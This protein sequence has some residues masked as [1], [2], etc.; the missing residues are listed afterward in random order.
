MIDRHIRLGDRVR[1]A[2]HPESRAGGFD[3][4]PDGTVATVEGF[5]E[6]LVPRLRRWGRKPG[7]YRSRAQP[8]LRLDGRT[9]V[10]TLSTSHLA[11][12]DAAEEARR[13]NAFDPEADE[14]AQRA[15]FLRDLPPTP[16]WE[17]DYVR[18]VHPRLRGMYTHF[19]PPGRGHG[20]A[21]VSF[22]NYDWEDPW[23]PTGRS[24]M[25]EVCARLEG[26]ATVIVREHALALVER[27]PVW[28]HVHGERITFADLR[29]EAEFYALLGLVAEVAN[30]RTGIYDWTFKELLSAIKDGLVDGLAGGFGF[31]PSGPPKGEHLVALRY[32]DR[33]LGKRVARAML[34]RYGRR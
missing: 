2:I 6:V 5:E 14:A 9:E 27:G 17:G 7:V 10:L 30:P 12:L 22:I 4:C 16:F 8:K 15:D 24:N 3:P 23:S 18:F 11:L 28:K 32:H 1:V 20:Q 33:D 21:Q 13:Q 34:C 31:D 26:G 25:Y 19:K 29:E